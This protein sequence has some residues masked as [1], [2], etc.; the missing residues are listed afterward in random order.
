LVLAGL[1]P[2]TGGAGQAACSGD[3]LLE[4]LVACAGVT[5]NAV[6]TA[7]GIELRVPSLEAEGDLDFR[8]T[9]GPSAADARTDQWGTRSAARPHSSHGISACAVIRGAASRVEKPSP[10]IPEVVMK[11]VPLILLM[12]LAMAAGVHA[13]TAS[14]GI[15]MSTDPAKAAAVEKHA[16]ELKARQAQPTQAKPAAKH[17]STKST[18]SSKSAKSTK[19]TKSSKKA[20]PQAK[21]QAS[22]AKPVAKQ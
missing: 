11:K 4:A 3:M 20:Q 13:Q 8:G 2:A 19:S 22:G 12:S 6:A 14:G 18:K 9:L 1:H 16:Q 5:M 21:Q 10:T 17:S 7:P 15:T